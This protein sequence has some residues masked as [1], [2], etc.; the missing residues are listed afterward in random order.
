MTSHNSIAVRPHTL[1]KNTDIND[2]VY[3]LYIK[4]L[5]NYILLYNTEINYIKFIN[6]YLFKSACNV[7]IQ[8]LWRL[9]HMK[10]TNKVKINVKDLKCP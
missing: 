3:K 4:Y 7:I 9:S 8:V 1:L 2:R 6:S 5:K 10:I